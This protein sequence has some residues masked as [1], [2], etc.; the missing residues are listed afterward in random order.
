MLAEPSSSRISFIPYIA[1]PE[2]LSARPYDHLDL[3]ASVATD[4]SHEQPYLQ[5]AT[6]HCIPG[7][8]SPDNFV[9]PLLDSVLLDVPGLPTTVDGPS[10][11]AGQGDVADGGSPKRAAHKGKRKASGLVEEDRPLRRFKKKTEI[12]C[13]FCRGKWL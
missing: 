4:Q 11:E 10:S 1:E 6:P 2:G 12:A 5:P 7:F 13:D 3:N 9:S 8:S